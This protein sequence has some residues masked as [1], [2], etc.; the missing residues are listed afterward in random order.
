MTACKRMDDAAESLALVASVAGDVDL[1][2][3]I[4]GKPRKCI[5]GKAGK[6][7]KPKNSPATASE[8]AHPAQHIN[9][10]AYAS[11]RADCLGVGLAW[12]QPSGHE[13]AGKSVR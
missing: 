5:V 4:A 13:K 11:L 7:G 3:R 1:L 9:A 12:C 10:S 6:S 8:T 2:K